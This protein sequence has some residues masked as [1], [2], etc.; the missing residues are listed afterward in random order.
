MRTQNPQRKPREQKP[1][2]EKSQ[3]FREPRWRPG[4]IRQTVQADALSWA[5][6]AAAGLGTGDGCSKAGTDEPGTGTRGARAEAGTGTKETEVRTDE[7]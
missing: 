2:R 3:K 5:K 4:K 7:T 6:K 1:N